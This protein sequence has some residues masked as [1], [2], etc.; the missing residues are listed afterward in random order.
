MDIS[1]TPNSNHDIEVC[2]LDASFKTF[3]ISQKK[4][5]TISSWLNHIP[6]DKKH[7]TL[8]CVFEN[9][10]IVI[11]HYNYD[12]HYFESEIKYLKETSEWIETDHVPKTCKMIYIMCDSS[13]KLHHSWKTLHHSLQSYPDLVSICDKED[14]SQDNGH[15]MVKALYAM[16]PEERHKMVVNLLW[17]KHY[18]VFQGLFCPTDQTSACLRWIQDHPDHSL[19]EYVLF[20]SVLFLWK[21]IWKRQR[22]K[23]LSHYWEDDAIRDALGECKIKYTDMFSLI[24]L[25]YL[26]LKDD[27]QMSS[28]LM[29]IV[30]HLYNKT[31]VSNLIN[32]MLSKH[33]SLKEQCAQ[34]LKNYESTSVHEPMHHTQ[35]SITSEGDDSMQVNFEGP[36]L[37]SHSFGSC[38]HLTT[39]SNKQKAHYLKNIK[40]KHLKTFFK[41]Q[42]A[43]EA[44]L[45]T[46]PTASI[47]NVMTYGFC[48]LSEASKEKYKYMALRANV[49]N[50]HYLS[51]QQIDIPVMEYICELPSS[52]IINVIKLLHK[53]ALRCEQ[54]LTV[55][56]HHTIYAYKKH[57]LKRKCSFDD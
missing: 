34:W 8:Q 19:R 17:N 9:D 30:A 31:Y 10:N 24:Q 33:E 14:A 36:S 50:I 25:I 18:E 1:S 26:L 3:S 4:H 48:D 55:L 43:L 42:D 46:Q 6:Y 21:L 38:S 44:F 27:V 54:F 22:G 20:H 32:E 37:L 11:M 5:K 57:T 29:Y 56:T 15:L 28:L 53:D 7:I 13:E 52:D 45:Q 49:S 23:L 47:V 12:T 41:T 2:A 51:K 16:P 40:G 39:L 35:W